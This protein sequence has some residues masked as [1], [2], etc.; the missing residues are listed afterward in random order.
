MY[1]YNTPGYQSK[2]GISIGRMTSVP[3]SV[4]PLAVGRF[5]P[6]VPQTT[7]CL[8]HVRRSRLQRVLQQL[9]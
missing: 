4:Q 9:R 3:S 8:N 6:H 5:S 2:M 7:L 1:L